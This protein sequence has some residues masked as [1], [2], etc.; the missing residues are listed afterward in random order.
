M[1]KTS[2]LLACAL[3]GCTTTMLATQGLPQADHAPAV[4]RRRCASRPGPPHPAHASQRPR[5]PAHRQRARAAGTPARRDGSRSAECDRQF[6]AA[7]AAGGVLEQRLDDVWL[8][9][10]AQDCRAGTRRPARADRRVLHRAG[11]APRVSS[12]HTTLV[13]PLAAIPADSQAAVEEAAAGRWN[14]SSAV[15][16]QAAGGAPRTRHQVPRSPHRS[17]THAAQSSTV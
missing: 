4:S 13:W 3:R 7:P 8:R 15:R 1:G 2:A 5:V 16:A 6:P 14:H 9:N 10:S 12:S 17:A 11:S